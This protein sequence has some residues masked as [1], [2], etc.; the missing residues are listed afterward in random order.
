MKFF[1]SSTFADLAEIRQVAIN[2]LEVLLIFNNAATGQAIAMEYFAATERTCKT[3]CLKELST[4]DVVIG[5]YGNR[6]GAL[7][8][9]S[10]LSMTEIEFDYAAEHNIP[11]LSFVLHTDNREQAEARFIKEK[12]DTWFGKILCQFCRAG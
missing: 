6:Y 2:I 7:D 9:E 1:I 5:I 3:E 4:S 12:I 8:E 11:I 10:A